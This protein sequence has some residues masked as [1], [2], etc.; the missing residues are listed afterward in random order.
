MGEKNN[1][2][3]NSTNEESYKYNMLYIDI[4][5]YDILDIL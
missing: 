4:S 1:H 2:A 3:T 5:P